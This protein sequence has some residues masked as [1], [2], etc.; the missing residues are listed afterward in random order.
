MSNKMIKIAGCEVCGNLNLKTVLDLGSHPLCDDLIKI[1]DTGTNIEYPIEILFCNVCNTA[2]QHYQVPKKILFPNN[3]HY[4]SALTKDVVLGMHEFVISCKNVIGDLKNLKVLDVGCN[5]GS[6]L[7]I[8]K[9]QGAITFGIEPTEAGEEALKKGHL[10][11]SDFITKKLAKEFVKSH[12]HL[13]IITFTNVFAHIE[14]LASVIEA[15]KILSKDSTTVVIENHYLGSVLEKNQFDTFYHEHPRTYSLK[16]FRFVADMLTKQITNIEFPNRYGGNIRIFISN[17]LPKNNNTLKEVEATEERFEKK[18][19]DLANKILEW[20][21]NK[22]IQIQLENNKFGKIPAKA[23]P[24]RA[25]ILIKLL[26]LNEEQISAVYEQQKSPKI[27]HY[28]PGTRIPILS[29]EYFVDRPDKDAP[30]LNLAWHISEEIH[31]Y[32]RK[33]GFSG[34]IIDVF[35]PEEGNTTPG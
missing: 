1:N 31:K 5:D 34:E 24:G 8:F 25:S 20:K 17:N 30:L 33:Q 16:S 11:T 9:M 23:F 29:D 3:Y 15:L 22:I 10:V 4:R 26:G 2:H 14:D 35:S 7:S 21:K 32:M 19:E 13:D 28:V 18:F 12:G 6:L 27:G